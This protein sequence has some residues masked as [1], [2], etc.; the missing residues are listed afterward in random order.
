MMNKLMHL[1]SPQARICSSIFFIHRHKTRLAGNREKTAFRAGPTPGYAL[2]YAI[3]WTA[4]RKTFDFLQV[5]LKAALECSLSRR[6]KLLQCDQ[7]PHI[8]NR[9][10]ALVADGT[11]Q[12]EL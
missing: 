7:T 3:K 12:Q 9:P 5:F 1:S 4:R 11:N 6:G 10:S 8:P 2:F